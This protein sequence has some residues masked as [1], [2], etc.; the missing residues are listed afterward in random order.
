MTAITSRT[1]TGSKTATGRPRPASFAAVERDL[2]TILGEAQVKTR[3]LD[4]ARMSHDASH[5]LLRPQAVVL[6]RHGDDVADALRVAARHGVP[7]TFRS[8]GTSLSGQAG[9]DGVLIDTRMNFRDIHVLDDGALVRCQPG[10]TVRAVN[11][12]LAPYRRAL[13]P[14]PASEVA[15]TIG[16]VVANN[17]SGMACGITANTYR[18][19]DSLRFALLSGTVV[20]TAEPDADARLHHDEP[21]LWEGLAR[22]RDRVRGNEESVRRIRHQFSMKN[23]MGYGLNSFL[24]HDDPAQILAHLMVGSEGTLGFIIAA[25]FRTVPVYP[26]AATALLVFDEIADATDALPA[27]IDAGA[28]T[29]ELMDAASL[30]VAQA[31]TTVV[32]QLVGL[33]VRAHTA[34]LVE[35]QEELREELDARLSVVDPLVH[36][37]AGLAAPAVFTTDAAERATSWYVRKGLYTA[38]AGARPTGTTAMLE[39]L[40]VPMPALT[41]TVRNLAELCAQHAYADS[42]IFGHARDANLHFMITADL[43]DAREVDRF[44]AFTEDMVDLVLAADGSLKAEHGTG[45]IMAPYVRRQ[46]GDELYD[47]MVQLKRL[48]DPGMTLNPGVIISSDDAIHLKNLK[49]SAPVGVPPEQAP[50]VDKCVECGYCE[51]VCPSRDLTTTPRQRIALMRDMAVASE[52]DRAAIAK[53]FGYD[54][55]ETCAVDSLCLLNCPVAIDT[56]K[57]MK[58]QRVARQT[59]ASQA[60][61]KYLAANWDK[62]LTLLRGGVGVADVLPAALLTGAT[63]AARTVLPTDLVPLVGDD[64]PGPGVSRRTAARHEPGDVVLFPSCIG[65]LFAPAADEGVLGRTAQGG[66]AFAFLALCDRAGVAVTLPRGVEK[67]CCGTVWRSKGLR[68]GLHEMAVGTA[69]TLLE[70]S[71]DGRSPVVTDASSCSHGLHELVGDLRGFGED[72]L[73]DRLAEVPT[74]D[75]VRYVADH[76]LP[77]LSVRRTLG[78][79]VVH[80]T[81]SDRHAGDVEALATVANRC[82]TTVVV[83]VDAGCCGFAGDR[84]MLH[85]ELTA[86]ATRPEAREATSR[87]FDAYVSTNRTCELGMSR[88]TGHAYRHVLEVLE[89]LTR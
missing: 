44:A 42:V 67:R 37:L 73:A 79:M 6:A 27:L 69:R 2:R 60:V 74:M 21:A 33:D 13:G 34:L 52:D 87:P 18:T 46:F 11:A 14:D 30:R 48:L 7:V 53:D 64:L 63:G 70:A 39:D 76:V 22:L 10:A 8:G 20:D 5:F 54:A 55:V 80:P 25:T 66:A 23:T 1:V 65:E 31:G 47:V 88:A 45:R 9:T 28:R 68:D 75:A 38:V 49:V 29:A 86:S 57:L 24:D 26:H 40:V 77:R 56:G 85:P 84:G 59:P 62:A 4:L 36:G 12:R 43:A 51:P 82:A 89:E 58:T 35:L 3:P 32:P 72:E 41:D 19:L 71:E 83:P 61:G 17:S 78:S 50:N 81:C 16:G 15:C